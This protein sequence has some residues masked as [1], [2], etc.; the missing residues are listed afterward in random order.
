MLLELSPRPSVCCC[1]HAGHARRPCP[2]ARRPDRGASHAR[3]AGPGAHNSQCSGH[4]T[5]TQ[6]RLQETI[7]CAAL[8][9]TLRRGLPDDV[10]R[11]Q[12]SSARPN[13]AHRAECL[14]TTKPWCMRRRP[15]GESASRPNARARKEKTHT[16][17]PAGASMVCGH[18]HWQPPPM[19]HQM[20]S[21]VCV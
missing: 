1:S 11:M 21:C 16:A 15:P 18:S 13:R 2:I 8:K 3:V 4:G 5:A 6:R 7:R 17:G 19:V 9:F 12:L 20:H 14:V 10:Q